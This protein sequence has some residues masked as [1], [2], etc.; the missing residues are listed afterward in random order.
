MGWFGKM[1]ETPDLS[2]YEK[3]DRIQAIRDRQDEIASSLTREEVESEQP[4]R[5]DEEYRALQREWE[6]LM[7]EVKGKVITVDVDEQPK[8]RGWFW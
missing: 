5:Y 8:K 4:T 6:T 7:D 3:V 2:V 1:F